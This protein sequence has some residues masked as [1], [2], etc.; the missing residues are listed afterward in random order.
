MRAKVPFSDIK[1]MLDWGQFSYQAKSEPHWRPILAKTFVFTSCV[2]PSLWYVNGAGKTEPEW[3]RRLR[4]FG[5]II[6]VEPATWPH[7]EPPTL[8]AGHLAASTAFPLE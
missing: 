2:D 4:D 7:L 6:T 1:Q 5:E 3:A 8:R